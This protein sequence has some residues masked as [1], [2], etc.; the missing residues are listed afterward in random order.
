[1]MGEAAASGI[2]SGKW[3]SKIILIDPISIKGVISHTSIKLGVAKDA[4]QGNM[5]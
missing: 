1:M 2:P 4:R 5:C 3:V